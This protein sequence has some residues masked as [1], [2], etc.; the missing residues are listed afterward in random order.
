MLV[1]YKPGKSISVAGALSRRYLN[2][3]DNTSE[4]MEAYGHVHLI[5]SSLPVSNQK[6]NDIKDATEVNLQC[7]LLKK[8]ILDGWP[9]L[10][11][12]CRVAI[13]EV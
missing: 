1:K 13:Q 11:K 4:S 6:L 2:E 10:R 7:K 8:I 9:G 3:T 5:V 12:E